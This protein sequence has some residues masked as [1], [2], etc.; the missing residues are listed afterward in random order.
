[1]IIKPW[2]KSFGTFLFKTFFILPISLGTISLN[3]PAFANQL[4]LYQRLAQEVF[5]AVREGNFDAYR[6][7]WNPECSLRNA[8]TPTELLC[9]SEANCDTISIE[10]KSFNLRHDL[11]ARVQ[12]T[13]IHAERITELGN[14]QGDWSKHVRQRIKAFRIKPAF[15]AWVDVIH[16][17]LGNKTVELGYIF[18]KDNGPGKAGTF[19]ILEGTCLSPI[20]PQDQKK[21]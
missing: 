2:K 7:L 4:T 5:S 20:S 8:K 21:Q 10:R 15:Y 13:G 18:M 6:Q 14:A 19:S 12:A 17:E 1:M 3:S 9:S 11:L 16:P